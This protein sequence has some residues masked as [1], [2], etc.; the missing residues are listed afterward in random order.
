MAP[1]LRCC[2]E[3]SCQCICHFDCLTMAHKR[4]EFREDG[5]G[6]CVHGSTKEMALAKADKKCKV[7]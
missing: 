4:A 6:H 1:M 5:Y 2:D 7:T 3:T